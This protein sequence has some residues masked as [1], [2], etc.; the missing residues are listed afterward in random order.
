MLR[1][2]LHGWWWVEALRRNRSITS[3]HLILINFFSVYK[4]NSTPLEEPNGH[5]SS[6]HPSP[7]TPNAI[8]TRA[9]WKLD[10]IYIAKI[11]IRQMISLKAIHLRV[12]RDRWIVY[13]CWMKSSGLKM[14]RA[15]SDWRS[16]SF[17][18]NSLIYPSTIFTVRIFSYHFPSVC[19]KCKME[20]NSAHTSV[21]K[22][23]TFRFLYQQ[24]TDTLA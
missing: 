4:T 20:T 2:A 16:L 1:T 12:I 5:W 23:L 17:H 6:K 19:W 10:Q 7:R 22:S 18:L 14:S 8:V 24:N 11:F 9:A 3:R 21:A 13:C 15:R